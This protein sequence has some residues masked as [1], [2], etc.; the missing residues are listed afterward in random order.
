TLGTTT[1]GNRSLNDAGQIAFRV[2][3]ADGRTVLGRADPGGRSHGGPGQADPDARSDGGP[4]QV[5]VVAALAGMTGKPDT[6]GAGALTTSNVRP[7][8]GSRPARLADATPA[9]L[10][11]GG[12]TAGALAEPVSASDGFVRGGAGEQPFADGVGGW[13]DDTPDGSLT[14][15][16]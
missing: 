9:G 15:M 12:K 6:P 10:P 5:D 2:G 16:G 1:I 14:R 3:L 11:S 8:E 7:D 4:G 13:L